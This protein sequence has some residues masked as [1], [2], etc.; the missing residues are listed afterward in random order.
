MRTIAIGCVVMDVSIDT[1]ALIDAIDRNLTILAE[2]SAAHAYSTAAMVH[3]CTVYPFKSQATL[4]VLLC[5]KICQYQVA[6]CFNDLLFANLPAVCRAVCAA[7][8][9]GAGHREDCSHLYNTGSTT[10]KYKEAHVPALSRPFYCKEC[11]LS[12]SSRPCSPSPSS[13]VQCL[14]HF[15]L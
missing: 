2:G 7:A 14:H 15:K 10:W 9:A 13:R 4:Q 5:D 8:A 6:I 11:V 3:Y 12:T 1:A